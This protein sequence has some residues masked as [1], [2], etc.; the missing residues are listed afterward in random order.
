M[1]NIRT[2]VACRAKKQ[3]T[4]LLRIVSNLG[5]AFLDETQKSNTRG[6]YICSDKKCINK[7]LKAKNITKC[8]KI[9]VSHDSIKELLKNLEE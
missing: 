7:L 9:D 5:E 8:I 4:E 6:V 2:C 3:K 1:K